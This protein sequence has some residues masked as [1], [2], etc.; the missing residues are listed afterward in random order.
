MNVTLPQRFM[1]L[2][3]NSLKMMS[4]CTFQLNQQLF[5]QVSCDQPTL[6]SPSAPE[7]LPLKPRTTPTAIAAVDTS[8]IKLGETSRGM[9][10]AI[11]GAG[12]WKI[13]RKYGYV[14]LGPF[15]FH[16]TEENRR[17]VYNS[18]LRT[19]FPQHRGQAAP[20][21]NQLP[22]RMANLLERWMQSSIAETMHGSVILF[23]GSLT[24]GTPD[25]PTHMLRG[26]L[27]AAR[28]N[29][30]IILAFT[31]MT[32]LRLN[33]CILTDM[34]PNQK[35]PCLIAVNGLKLKPPLTLLGDV[36]VA[37]LT[38]G[39]CTFRLDI[40]RQ[41]PPPE[42]IMAVE[43]LLGNDLITYSYPETL[44]LAH[45]L[46]TFTANEALAM[47]HYL[48]HRYGLKLVERPDIHKLLFGPFGK[49]E[50]GNE[51]L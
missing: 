50:C 45:I 2:S 28:E 9:I 13:G 48:R 19:Y 14:R 40:D 36:Y 26:I 4:K 12:V 10:I 18:L 49:G 1:E 24:A 3:I 51:A 33:G 46:C 20:G 21:F 25:T 5:Q 6:S 11:R 37:K 39:S 34:L 17:E 32:T 30:N 7:V 23:D 41:V 16:I 15:L 27:D 38:G 42:R 47:Q 29:G 8:T 43:K 44:R 31:K 22:M 35:P